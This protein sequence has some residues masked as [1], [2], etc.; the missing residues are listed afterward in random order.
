MDPTTNE[1]HAKYIFINKSESTEKGLYIQE[2]ILFLDL[3]IY[4]FTEL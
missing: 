3:V 2:I 1:K 4:V